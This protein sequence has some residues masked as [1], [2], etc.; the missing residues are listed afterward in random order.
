MEDP[1]NV[2]HFKGW[3]IWILRIREGDKRKNKAE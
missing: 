2:K 3:N 1:R